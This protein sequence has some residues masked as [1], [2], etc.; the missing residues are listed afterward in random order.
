MTASEGL[1]RTVN[2]K[3]FVGRPQPLERRELAE[4]IG[5]FSQYIAENNEQ[6]IRV[7]LE[8]LA[9][10]TLTKANCA[11]VAGLLA[12]AAAS[13]GAGVLPVEQLLSVEDYA[14]VEG[15]SDLIDMSPPL[16]DTDRECWT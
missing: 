9:C 8:R 1:S 2:E 6:A 3:I 15:G 13:S 4:A 16:T 5:R 10:G 11:E 14:N 12:G 7:E